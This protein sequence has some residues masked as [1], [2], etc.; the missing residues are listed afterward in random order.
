MSNVRRCGVPGFRLARSAAVLVAGACLAIGGCG[1]GAAGTPGANQG[2]TPVAGGSPAGTAAT[3][4]GGSPAS[5][6]A[7]SF[8]LTGN[9]CTDFNNIKY[10]VPTIPPGDAGNLPALKAAAVRVLTAAAGYFNA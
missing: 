8:K 2:S 3:G 10:H 9:L 7:T 4:P 1:G 6:G 5:A